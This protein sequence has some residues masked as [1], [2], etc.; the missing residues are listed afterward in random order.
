VCKGRGATISHSIQFMHEP[1]P[2]RNMKYV[3]AMKDFLAKEVAVLNHFYYINNPPPFLPSLDTKSERKSS[4]NQLVEGFIEGL[5][6]NF[7][8]TITTIL[9]TGAKLSF[10]T[11]SNSQHSNSYCPICQSLLTQ[12]EVK[13]IFSSENTNVIGLNK[14]HILLDSA[15]SSQVI[16]STPNTATATIQSN[17][18]SFVCYSCQQLLAECEGEG[19]LLFPP[20]I[21]QNIKNFRSGQSHD[22]KVEG[23]NQRIFD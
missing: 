20:Y 9:K 10:P 14:R 6:T 22:Q 12:S 17:N 11:N 16:H 13:N 8:Q 15:R 18:S 2:Q 7:P 21:S 3:R 19:E 5:Q 4:I 1:H 23:S